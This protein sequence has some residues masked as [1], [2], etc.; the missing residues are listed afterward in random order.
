MA[1]EENEWKAVTE[2]RA[3][4]G[5]PTAEEALRRM[6]EFEGRKER[7]VAAVRKSED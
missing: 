1:G 5:R 4:R 7:F 2:A 6:T 3:K